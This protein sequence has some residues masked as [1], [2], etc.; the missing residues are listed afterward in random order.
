[1]FIVDNKCFIH[2]RKTAG[3]SLAYSLTKNREKDI[4]YCIPHA[5][6]NS[7]PRVFNEEDIEFII[8]VRNPISWY[9]SV[10]SFLFKR[11]DFFS[12]NRRKSPEEI[13]NLRAFNFLFRILLLKEHNNNNYEIVGKDELFDRLLNFAEFAESI[14]LRGLLR[15]SLIYNTSDPI[16][17]SC[18]P[19]FNDIQFRDTFF[20]QEIFM[21]GVEAEKNI[22]V[23]KI[24]DGASELFEKFGTPEIRRNVA[25]PETRYKTTDEQKKLI[26]E[27]DKVLFEKYDYKMEI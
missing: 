24:D 21:F 16:L 11:F 8:A 7:L 5:S 12:V 19:N 6:I 10:V 25:N 3:T 26:F 9:E 14:N 27:R 15:K 20:Q 13:F 22:T 4:Q 23:F 2:L 17:K 18:Y 1:M